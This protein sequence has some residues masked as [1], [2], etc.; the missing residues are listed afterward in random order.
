[1]VSIVA[2]KYAVVMLLCKIMS[3][4]K[5]RRWFLWG[6]VIVLT[7]IYVV[8]IVLLSVQCIPLEKFWNP[9]LPGSCGLFEANLDFGI[10]TTGLKPKICHYANH[11]LTNHS[12]F[13]SLRP[14]TCPV[15]YQHRVE[16]SNQTRKE[17]WH[18][19]CHGLGSPVFDPLGR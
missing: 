16:S 15:S 9:S 4:S 14:G 13:G 18:L 2:P 17:S 3:P 19:C 8:N 5:P 1:M 11:F 12:M 10:F 7:A 6:L